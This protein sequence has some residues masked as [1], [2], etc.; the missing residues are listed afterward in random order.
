MTAYVGKH[1]TYDLRQLRKAADRDR[2]HLASPDRYVGR[3]RADA[4]PDTDVTRLA[5]EVARRLSF[6][7]LRTRVSYY[8]GGFLA[9]VHATSPHYVTI[10]AR[11]TIVDNPYDGSGV[12]STRILDVISYRIDNG[13]WRSLS[14]APEDDP[15]GNALT[16]VTTLLD[17]IRYG[18]AP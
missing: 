7:D 12:Y 16:I 8:H 13:L 14:D 17:V 18:E 2:W 10:A 1:R 3:H 11:N 4:S 6:H 15:V 9:V 5:A